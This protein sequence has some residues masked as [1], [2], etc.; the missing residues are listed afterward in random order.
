[1]ISR[2]SWSWADHGRGAALEMPRV[3]VDPEAGRKPTEALVA[4]RPVATDI[5]AALREGHRAV[6]L[7]PSMRF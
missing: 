3:A 2:S 4:V 5:P 1:M 6:R 7:A